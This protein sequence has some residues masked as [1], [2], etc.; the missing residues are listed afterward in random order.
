MGGDTCGYN[1]MYTNSRARWNLLPTRFFDLSL[2][3]TLV[4]EDNPT[5]LSVYM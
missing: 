5:K 2:E 3:K 4:N 1:D